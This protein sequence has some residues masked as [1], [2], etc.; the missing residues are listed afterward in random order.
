MIIAIYMQ[1]TGL[2]AVPSFNIFMTI[3]KEKKGKNGRVFIRDYMIIKSPEVYS[4][5]TDSYL[6][7]VQGKM[8]VA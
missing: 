3:R 5:F 8:I 7:C 6:I 4:R 2:Q 1:Y